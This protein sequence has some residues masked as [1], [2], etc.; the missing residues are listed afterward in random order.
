MP[1]KA[2]NFETLNPNKQLHRYRYSLKREYVK[3]GV[4]Y[5]IDQGRICTMFV[6]DET[7][8]D[9]ILRAQSEL[10]AERK[11]KFFDFVIVNLKE[12][13]QYA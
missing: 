3:H 4:N 12:L 6:R 10:M 8:A 7:K 2:I 9:D 11:V 1:A 13:S 5:H